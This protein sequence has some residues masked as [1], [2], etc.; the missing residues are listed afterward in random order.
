[1]PCSYTVFPYIKSNR[2]AI[3]QVSI[4]VNKIITSVKLR[5]KMNK[6]KSDFFPFAGSQTLSV[7]FVYTQF[8]QSFSNDFFYNFVK[9]Q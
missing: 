5:D 4:M 3:F 8:K 6:K 2:V 7:L 1:M 9:G